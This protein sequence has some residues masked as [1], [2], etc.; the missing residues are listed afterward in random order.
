MSKNKGF[1]IIELIVVIAIFAVILGLSWSAFFGLQTSSFLNQSAENLA[2]DV[3]YAQRAA[4]LLKRESNDR[5]IQG[6]GVD[7]GGLSLADPNSRKYNVIKWCDS[8]SEYS[9]FNPN[10]QVDLPISSCSG[11]GSAGYAPVAGKMNLAFPSSSL[12]FTPENNVQYI[13]FESITG[14]PHFYDKNR[15]PISLSEARFLIT[16][17]NRNIRVTVKITGEVLVQPL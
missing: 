7:L 14:M 5:W 4:I 11:V 1:T 3:T 13:V 9:D 10:R 6:I 17:R 16:K 15:N 12:T 8:S 2:A